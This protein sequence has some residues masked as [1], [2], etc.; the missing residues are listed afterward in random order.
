MDVKKVDILEFF[1]IILCL[2][3]VVVIS[4][5]H[6]S[7]NGYKG[8]SSDQWNVVWAIAENF[9][10]LVMSILLSIFGSKTIRLMFF[11][12]FIPYFII[13]LIY[14]FS[15]FSQVYIVSRELWEYIWSFV[16]VFVLGIGLFYCSNIVVRSIRNVGE[17]IRKFF[18][19]RM[20]RQIIYSCIDNTN[21]SSNSEINND[22]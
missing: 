3:F 1:A 19:V 9:L 7:Y 2:L 18:R 21:S 10:S 20:G 12:L 13:K 15:V 5:Y 11:S 16:C 4:L 14:Q 17:K 22:N 6:L 8:L